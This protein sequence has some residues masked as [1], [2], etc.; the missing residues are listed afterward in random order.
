MFTSRASLGTYWDVRNGQLRVYLS[1]A[2][3]VVTTKHVMF[4]K[5][6]FPLA[7]NLPYNEDHERIEEGPDIISTEN[8]FKMAY[9]ILS[10]QGTRYLSG[11]VIS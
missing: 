11:P 1:S 7:S 8:N 10:H 5:I 9:G 3:S 6:L 4:N 2:D